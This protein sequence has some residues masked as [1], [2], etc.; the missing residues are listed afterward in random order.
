VS[1]ALEEEADKDAASRAMNDAPGAK[2]VSGDAMPIGG[3]SSGLGAS[4]DPAEP[5]AAS[6]TTAE[7]VHVGKSFTQSRFKP[8]RQPKTAILAMV[9]NSVQMS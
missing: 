8:L 6:T 4:G 3:K 7:Q 5:A 2:H 1:L 9:A